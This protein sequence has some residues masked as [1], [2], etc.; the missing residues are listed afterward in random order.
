[1]PTELVEAMLAA[2]ADLRALGVP[3][4]VIG[5]LAASAWNYYR[6]TGD[7]DLLVAA[8][9]I[10]PDGLLRSLQARGYRPYKVPP[11]TD[12]DGERVLQ[13]L[14]RPPAKVYEYRID[15]FLAE[16]EFHR[17]ALGRRVSFRLPDGTTEVPV[18]TCED[19]ILLK[20]RAARVL[21]QG[22]VVALLQE[23]H[24]DLDFN[25]MRRWV[26]TPELRRVWSDCWRRS[27]PTEADPILSS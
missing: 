23:N 12:F 25:Y 6:A 20:V 9:V 1:M 13:L 8:D 11:L 7:V 3:T 27:F 18:V 26:S 22:D 17:T 15:L 5:G 19:L 10:S 21:D 24:P 14:L 16:T 2:S 4:A